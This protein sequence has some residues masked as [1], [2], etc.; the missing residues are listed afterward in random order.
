VVGPGKYGGG[1]LLVDWT[2]TGELQI[3]GDKALVPALLLDVVDP[4]DL[5]SICSLISLLY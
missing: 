3:S 5:W 1:I 2:M 4:S